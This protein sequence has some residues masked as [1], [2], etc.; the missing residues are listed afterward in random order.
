MH[1]IKKHIFI[2]AFF[3]IISTTVCGQNDHLEPFDDTTNHQGQLKDYYSNIFKLLQSKLSDTVIARY[4]I[5]PSW[6]SESILSV[7]KDTVKNKF[8]IIYLSC[9]ES[10]WYSKNK[11]KVHVISDCA[12]YIDDDLAILTKK[13]FDK[14][15]LQIKRPTQPSYGLD[16]VTYYFSTTDTTGRIITGQKWSPE[17][18]TKMSKLVQVCHDLT[19]FTCDN[20]IIKADLIEEINKLINEFN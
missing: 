8:K 11:K 14:V 2:L 4:I 17:D 13:L 6:G 16:G 20:G 15:T 7:E 10:Y 3:T 12:K 19:L 1:M 9:S 18:G 5:I